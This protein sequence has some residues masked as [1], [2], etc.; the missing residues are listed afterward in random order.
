VIAFFRQRSND[1]GLIMSTE[2]TTVASGTDLP[3]P[4]LT[5]AQKLIGVFLGFALVLGFFLVL[6]YQWYV[7][8]LVNRQ[9]ELRVESVTKAFASGVFKP[10]VERNFIQVNK[11]AETTAQLPD[12]AY[13]AVVNERGSLVAG[14][15][16]STEAFEPSFVASAQEKGFPIDVV[17]KTALADNRDS[18][19]MTLNVGGQG[20]MDYALRVPQTGSVVHVGL[21]VDG[22]K[23]AVRATLVP[24]LVILL[25]MAVLGG[26]TLLLLARTVSRPIRQLSLQ[27]EAI[28]MGKL[29]E[30]ID[31][32]AGGEIGQ[33]A[34]SFKRMQASIRYMV[35][36]LRKSHQQH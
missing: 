34:Q 5:I 10:M 18:G 36:Q 31:I 32:T 26:M 12:V 6:V 23:A 8:P 19:R 7:P 29:N 1:E 21:F 25:L 27:A 3:N 28:S 22:V 35:T 15:F 30:V 13:A 11:V 14:I 16:G 24:L 2:S 20:I 4:G 17:Q 9:I 33:L